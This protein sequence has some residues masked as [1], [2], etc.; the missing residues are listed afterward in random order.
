MVIN[1]AE[2]ERGSSS[3]PIWLTKQSDMQK[4]TIYSQHILT[5]VRIIQVI[6]QQKYIVENNNTLFVE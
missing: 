1:V 6:I 2:R 4:S 5:A 3:S